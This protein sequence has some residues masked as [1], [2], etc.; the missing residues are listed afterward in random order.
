MFDWRE[1]RGEVW[2]LTDASRESQFF[3]FSHFAKP[4]TNR[5]DGGLVMRSKLA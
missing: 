1:K 2:L 4:F 5:Q 3:I